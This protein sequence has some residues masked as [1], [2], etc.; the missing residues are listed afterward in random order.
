MCSVEQNEITG[1]AELAI[2]AMDEYQYAN[3]GQQT[4]YFVKRVLQDPEMRKLHAQVKAELE[5]SGYF[6]K[7]RNL[8][9]VG[10]A[11]QKV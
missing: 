9:A 8:P 6:D 3:I 1:G 4:F 5:T 7:L 10:P 2:A 11:A